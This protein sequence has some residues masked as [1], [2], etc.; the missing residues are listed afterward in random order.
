MGDNLVF[1]YNFDAGN[2]V[3]DMH[4]AEC[5]VGVYRSGSTVYMETQQK[6]ANGTFFPLYTYQQ[7]GC[8]GNVG[9]FL[10]AEQ[11]SLDIYDVAYYPYFKYIGQTE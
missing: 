6:M 2:Y 9:F 7:D 8:T 3:T 1:D 11:A 4:G 5:W 10:T